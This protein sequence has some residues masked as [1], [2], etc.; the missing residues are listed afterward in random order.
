M[1]VWHMF[2]EVFQGK[3]VAWDRKPGTGGG[4]FP[5]Q[6]PRLWRSHINKL[7]VTKDRRSERNTDQI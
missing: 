3:G 7:V 2:M 1:S 6:I 5:S 4:V